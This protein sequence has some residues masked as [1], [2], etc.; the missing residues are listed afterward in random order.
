M[1]CRWAAAGR[2]GAYCVA[3]RTACWLGNRKGIRPVKNPA[4][5]ILKG[6]FG[7]PAYPKV[8]PGKLGLDKQKQEAQLMPTKPRDAFRGQ[9]RSPN[10]VPF[11]IVSYYCPIVTR[12]Y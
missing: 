9:S 7:D 3:M 12:P 8:I 4:T 1:D 6:Y 11:H 2:A 10:I 5:A